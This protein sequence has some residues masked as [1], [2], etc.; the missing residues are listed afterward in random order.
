MPQKASFRF[1]LCCLLLAA[2]HMPAHARYALED[3]ELG[4]E[5]FAA[6]LFCLIGLP[7]LLGLATYLVL[8][9]CFRAY[10]SH[11]AL[12]LIL[13]CLAWW[14]AFSL[15][16]QSNK[17]IAPPIVAQA[18]EEP[19]ISVYA[20]RQALLAG[21]RDSLLKAQLAS[22]N[23]AEISARVEAEQRKKVEKQRSAQAAASRRESGLG[24][25]FMIL[26]TIGASAIGY[27]TQRKLKAT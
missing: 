6:I 7:L 17:T 24:L 20:H 27:Y 23:D 1:L 13:S 8:K 18:V 21:T 25:C 19:Y 3:L 15:L 2:S 14:G 4:W 16:I 10:S 12:S 22:M 11:V 9:R 5:F 26:S